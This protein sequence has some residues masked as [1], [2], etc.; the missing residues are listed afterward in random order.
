MQQGISETGDEMSRW[1]SPIARDS[2]PRPQDR[3]ESSAS[4]LNKP[5]KTGL[6]CSGRASNPWTLDFHPLFRQ[7]AGAS[8]HSAIVPPVPRCTRQSIRDWNQEICFYWYFKKDASAATFPIFYRIE[9]KQLF[10]TWLIFFSPFSHQNTT[11]VWMRS[12]SWPTIA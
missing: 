6:F 2:N 11:W 12:V 5:Q 10:N 4:A 7:H 1:F 9:I 3:G 8:E